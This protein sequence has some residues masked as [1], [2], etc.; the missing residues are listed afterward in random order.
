MNRDN[1]RSFDHW[2]PEESDVI[3]GIVWIKAKQPVLWAEYGAGIER[4]AD[5]LGDWKGGSFRLS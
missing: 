4:A 3:Q 2:S 5:T 1:L